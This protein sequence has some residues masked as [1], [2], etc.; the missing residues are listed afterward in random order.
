MI[1]TPEINKK[2]SV[3]SQR[4]K[5]LGGTLVDAVKLNEVTCV[6]E[7]DRIGTVQSIK[8]LPVAPRSKVLPKANNINYT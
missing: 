6:K 4:R 8:M 2:F 5:F 7:T 3:L 1:V